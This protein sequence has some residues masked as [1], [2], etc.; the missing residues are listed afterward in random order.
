VSIVHG[1]GLNSERLDLSGRPGEGGERGFGNA[2][3]PLNVRP[4]SGNCNWLFVT[5]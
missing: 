5:Y 1:L 4:T 3:V 2:K